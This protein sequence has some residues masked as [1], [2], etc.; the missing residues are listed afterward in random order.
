MSHRTTSPTLEALLAMPQRIPHLALV[1]PPSLPIEAMS[2]F[3]VG[4]AYRRWAPYVANIA[5]RLL[6]S[7]EDV[8]DVLHDVFM[9]AVKGLRNLRDPE[10][11]R[12]WLASVTTRVV[13]QRLRARG[14]RRW[15][16]LGSVPEVNRIVAP[17]ASPEEQALLARVYR[18]LDDVPIKERSAWILRMIE[19]D[20]LASVATACG[21]SLA[22]AKRRITAAQA[23][24]DEVL[25]DD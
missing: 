2:A 19:G 22:T 1:P 7:R 11:I 25:H 5:A 14:L 20:D 17:G 12:G 9:A 21:C 18:V 24:I 15:L 16:G 10:A 23:R 4:A 3:D 6:G 8:E 13:S